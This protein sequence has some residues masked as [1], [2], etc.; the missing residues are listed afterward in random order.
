MTEESAEQ[1]IAKREQ[2]D[3]LGYVKLGEQILIAME[4]VAREI[5]GEK[6]A[7]VILKIAAV[8]F[9]L[10][11]SEALEILETLRAGSGMDVMKR[12]AKVR[13]EEMRR[14]RKEYKKELVRLAVRSA[15]GNRFTHKK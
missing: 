5:G 9:P 4:E 2:A 13:D 11:S 6:F 15:V 3:P 7:E 14:E 10:P 12:A 8:D 1:H